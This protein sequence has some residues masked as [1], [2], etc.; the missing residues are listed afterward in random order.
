MFTCWPT[1]SDV[2]I[3]VADDVDDIVVVVDVVDVGG[4][5]SAAVVDVIFDVI[6]LM[7]SNVK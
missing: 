3:R 7:C 1:F 5:G 2:G 6:F 4:G